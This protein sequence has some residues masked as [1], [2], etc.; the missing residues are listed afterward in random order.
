MKCIQVYLLILA[1]CSFT[2]ANM[3]HYIHNEDEHRELKVRFK[4]RQDGDTKTSKG[5]K[6]SYTSKASKGSKSSKGSK[7]SKAGKAGSDDM[8]TIPT[9]SPS[10]DMFGRDDSSVPT[11]L[12]T[13]SK[14]KRG[15]SD[16]PSVVPTVTLSISPTSTPSISPSDT[17]IGNRRLRQNRPLMAW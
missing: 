15:D 9:S 1:S 2:L 6:S 11:A 14:V 8:S 3:Q 7:A 17:T 12:P 5:G 16:M 10:I 13:V 4:P